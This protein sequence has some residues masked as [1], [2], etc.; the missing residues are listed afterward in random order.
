LVDRLL[1]SHPGRYR[2][3]G[4]PDSAHNPR[5]PILPF[6]AALRH[7]KCSR[8]SGS[9]MVPAAIGS[10]QKRWGQRWALR[11]CILTAHQP[12]TSCCPLIA[13]PFFGQFHG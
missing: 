7:S 1:S 6:G 4:T 8:Q 9:Q 12:M 10:R 3:R 11:D 2:Q 13:Q 5:G